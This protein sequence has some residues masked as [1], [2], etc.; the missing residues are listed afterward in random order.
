MA[1]VYAG[2]AASWRIFRTHRAAALRASIC[3][4]SDK[5]LLGGLGQIAAAMTDA[6]QR[7]DIFD[8]PGASGI[9]THG[10]LRIQRAGKS[11]SGPPAFV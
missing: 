5:F 3:R 8:Q 4:R 9:H 7:I 10:K 2:I 11:G 6:Y 1:E